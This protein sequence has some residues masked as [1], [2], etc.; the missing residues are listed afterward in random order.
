MAIIS[1]RISAIEIAKA[2][3]LD[4]EVYLLNCED[5]LI[6]ID[7]GFTNLC[8]KNIENELKSLI[9]R[10]EDVKLI[11]ITHAHED[12]ILNLKKIVELTGAEVMVGRGDSDVLFNETGVRATVELE[13]GD[14]IDACGGVEVIQIPG[15]SKG[16]LSYFLKEEKTV[17][18]GDS[19]FGDVDGNLYF[20]PEK[21]SED[22]NKAKLKLIRLLDYDFDRVLLSH[23]RNILKGGKQKVK[24]LLSTEL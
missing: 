6:L 9:K 17:I 13:N 4:T 19:M 8:L 23:G 12:H 11:L 16:N 10:W 18:V 1:N 24:D 21:Y 2:D 15:H 5:G 20:P 7:V 22:V 3:G 14:V